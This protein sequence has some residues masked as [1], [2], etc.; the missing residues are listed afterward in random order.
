MGAGYDETLPSRAPFMFIERHETRG[1]VGVIA[2]GAYNVFGLIGSEKGGVAIVMESPV[3]D[4]LATKDIPWKPDERK[5]VTDRLLRAETTADVI[6]AAVNEGGFVW[7]YDP[8][9]SM[10]MLAVG[11]SDEC[12]A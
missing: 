4:V 6:R 12:D 8:E 5:V 11:E 2:F 7:R 1:P 9:H 10:K 3:A